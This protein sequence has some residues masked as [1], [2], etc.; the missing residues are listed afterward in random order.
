MKRNKPELSLSLRPVRIQR[1]GSH[2]L[3]PGG[4]LSPETESSSMLNLDFPVSRLGEINV[5][6][7]SQPV[8]GILFWLPELIKIFTRDLNY[9]RQTQ[10]DDL[11][12]CN[13][14]YCLKQTDTLGAAIAAVL[15]M[16]KLK[17][18]EIK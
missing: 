2:I 13:L 11:I 14:L 15:Q 18:R 16:K 17:H 12:F 5:C 7:L 8:Y 3:K 6:C 1:E 10:T 9:G 4:G